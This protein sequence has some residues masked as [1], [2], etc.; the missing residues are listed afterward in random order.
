MMMTTLIQRLL[1]ELQAPQS[2]APWIDELISIA[3]L[4]RSP[5]CARL[6]VAGAARLRVYVSAGLEQL[7]R[8]HSS[9][10]Y[11]AA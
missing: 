10:P 3:K 2:Q 4:Q 6:S 1:A 8:A 11:A 9:W 7:T 5:G